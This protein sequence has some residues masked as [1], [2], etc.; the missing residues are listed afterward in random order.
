MIQNSLELI[1]E[2]PVH[3]G[4]GKKYTFLDYFLD[5]GF[6]HII[7]TEKIFDD[8]NKIEVIDGLC[9]DIENKIINGQAQIDIREFF[10]QYGIDPWRYVIKKIR[11][12]V[13]PS[14]RVQISQFI[15]QNGNCYIP[16]SS[17]KGAIRT[18]YLFDY[19]DKDIDKLV[20][21]LEDQRIRNKYKKLNEE[22]IGGIEEDIFRHI[23]VTDSSYIN[24]N[25]FIVIEAKRYNNIKKQWGNPVYLE[26][27]DKETRIEFNVKIDERFKKSINDIMSWCNNLSKII[28]EYEMNNRYN[29]NDLKKY[30]KSLYDNIKEDGEHF[31]LNLG[32]GGGHI[33]KTVY[34]LLW[35]Y[36]KD[37]KLI[38]G[39]L[40]I[41]KLIKKSMRVNN[42]YE[43]PR[44]RVI[45]NN[46]PIGWVKISKLKNV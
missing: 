2:T 32:F 27:I 6:I 44:T 19:Y 4:N 33:T 18:A 15:N 1:C 41:E 10:G 46:L 36:K 35:K 43:F 30:Y 25:N 39:L 11:T 38:R 42:F 45:F 28:A 8:I 12:N 7:D 34:L 22:A 40:K 3:I 26:V 31:Y 9:R 17:I 14:R 20:K 21:I 16:G 29:S 23:Q 13:K 5:G 24:K 37:L